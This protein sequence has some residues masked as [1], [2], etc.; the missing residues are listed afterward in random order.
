MLHPI[1]MH[2]LV[3]LLLLNGLPYA[4]Y[5][6]DADTPSEHQV[7]P[8]DE[9]RE[10]PR[11]SDNTVEPMDEV[12][13]HLME[14]LRALGAAGR[15]TYES[16]MPL[17]QQKTEEAL[18]ETQHLLKELE[19]SMQLKP[20]PSKPNPTEKPKTDEAGMTAI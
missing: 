1:A 4:A 13:Q 15:L 5:A 9:K 18:K 17:L 3:I 6:A 16:Q 20:E 11:K 10:K 12:R 8:A 2:S 19:K 7:A 14:A